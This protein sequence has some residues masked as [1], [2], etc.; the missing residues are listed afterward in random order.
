MLTISVTFLFYLTSIDFFFFSV[1]LFFFFKSPLMI[2]VVS[3]SKFPSVLLGWGP[4]IYCED[5]HVLTE[6]G[7]FFSFGLAPPSPSLKTLL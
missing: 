1:L 7:I 2:T 5:C 3:R 6:A 4:F